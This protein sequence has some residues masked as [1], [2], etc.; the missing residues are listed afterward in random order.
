MRIPAAPSLTDSQKPL[1]PSVENEKAPA[2]GLPF[3]TTGSAV[4]VYT[5]HATVCVFAKSVHFIYTEC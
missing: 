5:R 3:S 1:N 4:Y 2:V